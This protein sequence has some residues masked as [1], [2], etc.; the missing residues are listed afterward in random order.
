MAR[1]GGGGAVF[2][3]ASTGPVN[4][5][6]LGAAYFPSCAVSV[7]FVAV[8]VAVV[9]LPAASVAAAVVVRRESHCQEFAL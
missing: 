3:V 1:N 2:A 4:K 6:V 8:L 5:N 7:G 9:V